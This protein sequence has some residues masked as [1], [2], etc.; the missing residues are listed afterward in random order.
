MSAGLL[1]ISAT[2]PAALAAQAPNANP[3]G[4]GATSNGA[5]E[6]ARNEFREAGR[7]LAAVK[8]PRSIEPATR[9]EA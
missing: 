7:A 2:L 1:T 3:A 8:L 9:F 6:A 4:P 5:T